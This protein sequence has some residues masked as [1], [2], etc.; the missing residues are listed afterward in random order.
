M[1]VRRVPCGTPSLKGLVDA[2]IP[3]A[4]PMPEGA[5]SVGQLAE[6]RSAGWAGQEREN[7][8]KTKNLEQIFSGRRMNICSKFWVLFTGDQSCPY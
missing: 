6:R 5:L 3:A 4:R 7:R 1:V 2:D 8:G